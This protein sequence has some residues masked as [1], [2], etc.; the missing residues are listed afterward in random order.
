P[1]TGTRTATSTQAT[2]VTGF[3][4]F[5]VGELVN[6]T[7]TA[8]AGSGGTISPSGALSVPDG[9]SQTF[10]ITP[11]SGYY[12]Q[13]VLVD[14]SSVGGVS[15]YTFSNVHANHTIAATFAVDVATIGAQSTTSVI[16]PTNTCV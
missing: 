11:G 10:T 3:S 8:S 15:S 5:Q 7:I 6:Y 4:D 13:D 12:V 1:G 9:G 14:G 2:G 16:C